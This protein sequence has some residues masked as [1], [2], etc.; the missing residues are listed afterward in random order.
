M[1][2]LVMRISISW[3]FL[4]SFFIYKDSQVQTFPKHGKG[5]TF[6]LSKSKS[7]CPEAELRMPALSYNIFSG[8]VTCL[9]VSGLSY[10]LQVLSE[11]RK[12]HM[13]SIC[14]CGWNSLCSKLA[15]GYLSNNRTLCCTMDIKV[16]FKNSFLPH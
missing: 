6:R 10:I 13:F 14:S 1:Q 7:R 11:G 5:I 3:G 9:L 16:S 12:S 8:T 15:L 4:V 2:T